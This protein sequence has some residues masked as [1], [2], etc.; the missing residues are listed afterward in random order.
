M[1]TGVTMQSVR[2]LTVDSSENVRIAAFLFNGLGH[3]AIFSLPCAL[4]AYAVHPS[5]VQYL[6]FKRVANKK[7]WLIVLILS[8]A[9]IPLVSGIAELLEKIPLPE[10]LEHMKE[11][12]AL[13]QKAMMNLQTPAEFITALILTGLI[14]A[15]GEEMLFRAIMM[16]FAAKRV[17]GSIFWPIFIS[18]T[19]F[20]LMHGNVVGFIPLLISGLMLGYVYY[21]TGSLWL[22]I[23][24]HMIVNSVQVGIL[25]FGRHNVELTEMMDSNEIPWGLF[26]GGILVF[27]TSFYWLWKN[28][29]PLPANWSSDFTE[30]ELEERKQQNKLF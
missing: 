1:I 4:F 9:A 21:L 22:S 25:Y 10:S 17:K 26:I 18:G 12:F 6:G 30:E 5:P 15:F 16:K 7:H 11:R 2:S 20:A 3:I 8:L 19:F 23:F 13:Q 24:S 27:I 28:R 29:T 14:A